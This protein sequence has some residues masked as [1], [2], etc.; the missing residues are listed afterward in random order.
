M[1]YMR[2]DTTTGEILAHLQAA[3]QNAEALVTE[4]TGILEGDV[5]AAEFWVHDG[6]F[7]P[8]EPITI[9]APSIAFEPSSATVVILSNLPQ[10]C[11]IHIR[12][13]ANMPF[14]AQVVQEVN[15]ELRFAPPLVGTYVCR[16]VGRY[17][18]PEFTFEV[19]PVE[20]IK[21]RRQDEVSG[22]KEERLLGGFLWNGH[23]WDADAK[24][25]SN[26][27]SMASAVAA[28]MELPQGFFWTTYDN[29]DIPIDASGVTALS[30]AMMTF[31]FSTHAH[32]RQL[33]DTIEAQSSN[34]EVM[35]LDLT[36]NWPE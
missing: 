5:N 31:I 29:Q 11:S 12:G 22:I 9:N 3:P 36:S 35:A 7:K 21:S 10:G 16:V 14:S 26:V 13:T 32:A 20:V 27:T 15:G 24:A 17:N 4:G 19:Q 8:R 28:G 23:R 33:K 18:C 1:A 2:F 6:Q 30:A 34:S 25:Q